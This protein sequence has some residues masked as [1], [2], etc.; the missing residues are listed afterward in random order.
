LARRGRASPGQ[1]AGRPRTHALPGPAQDPGGHGRALPGYGA[2]LG[3]A[4]R[5]PIVRPGYGAEL[6]GAE[7]S[8]IVQPDKSLLRSFMREDVFVFPMSFAQ[9]RLWFLAQLE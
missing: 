5:S 1:H 9:E 2:E 4:E 3:G 7:R 6:G 8:P